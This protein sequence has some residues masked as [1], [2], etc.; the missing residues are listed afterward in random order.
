MEA[1]IILLGKILKS[2]VS[3]TDSSYHYLL[4]SPGRNRKPAILIPEPLNPTTKCRVRLPLTSD[5]GYGDGAVAC[6]LF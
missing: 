6:N 3:F 5:R 4:M 2:T 1:R